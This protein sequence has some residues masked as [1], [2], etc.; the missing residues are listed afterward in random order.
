VNSSKITIPI[1]EVKIFRGIVPVAGVLKDMTVILGRPRFLPFFI[2]TIFQLRR[3]LLNE[4]R[5]QA[6]KQ[7]ILVNMTGERLKGKVAIITGKLQHVEQQANRTLIITGGA[8]GFGAAIS[9]RFVQEGC[10]VL[11]GD[12]D[13][14]GAAA[15]VGSLGGGENV[16]SLKMDVASDTDW[17]KAVD[18]CLNE[19]GRIDILVNNAGTTYQNKVRAWTSAQK[20]S[21]I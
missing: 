7:D 1:A 13:E 17:K 5:R 15:Q 8:S 14:Q 18:L 21:I 16:K 11:I 20:E 10:I 2:T 19:W 12:I 9:T 4:Q 3:I 6:V